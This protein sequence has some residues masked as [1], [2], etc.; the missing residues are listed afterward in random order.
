MAAA[1]THTA[2]KRARNTPSSTASFV[3][4]P[5]A[6]TPSAAPSAA[7]ASTPLGDDVRRTRG[8]A[9]ADPATATKAPPA[10]RISHAV[11]TWV[12]LLDAGGRGQATT[13]RTP[14]NVGRRARGPGADTNPGD[15]LATM[16]AEPV[17]SVVICTHRR[18]QLLPISVDA[19]LAQNVDVPFEV[20]VVN[21]DDEPLRCR[22]PD[23]PRLS[24]I[25]AERRGLCE[26][27]N[28]G[29]RAGT[30]RDRGVDR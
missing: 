18:P 22:L 4:A 17:V 30:G 16:R 1:S 29:I 7:R 25:T 12:L 26:G 14:R 3:G 2:P 9:I 21:D 6:R 11:S 13:G 15:S 23:D 27:R 5:G 20:V 19:V 10:V 28:A 8:A 24:V